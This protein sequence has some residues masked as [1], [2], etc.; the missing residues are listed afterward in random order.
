MIALYLPGQSLLHR[1]PAGFKL[2]ALMGLGL[3]VMPQTSVLALGPGLV[4]MVALYR[5]SL[6]AGGW[7][8]L[9]ILR[10]LGLILLLIFVFHALLGDWHLGLVAVLRLALM[11]LA[12]N[13]VTLTTRMDAMLEA[14]TPL[15]RPL[16]WAGL[17]PKVPALAIVLVIRFVPVLYQVQNGLMEAWRARGG[18]AGSW[19]L[20]APLLI[21]A[22]K[23]ADHVAEALAARGGAAGFRPIEPEG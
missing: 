15:F 14:V 6:G 12:A 19:R 11:V 20:I 16:A 3:L 9:R 7:Q 23:M 10:A 8:Q 4:A 22:L 5:L 18:G 2:L 21:Q 1:C 13:L 17:P